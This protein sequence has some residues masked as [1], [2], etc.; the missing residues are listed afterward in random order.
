MAYWWVNQ[1]QTFEEEFLGSYLWAPKQTKNGR[2][3]AHWDAMTDVEVD[4]VIVHY[5]GKPHFQ[6]RSLSVATSGPVNHE[7]PA[8]LRATNMWEDDGW[9][10][11]V[12]H[13]DAV[14]PLHRDRAAALGP[15]EPPFTVTGSVKQGYLWP[16]SPPFARQLLEEMDPTGS[17]EVTETTRSPTA[18][19]E[20][21]EPATVAL[22]EGRSL[23][24]EQ[25]L[26]PARRQAVRAEW[27]LVDAFVRDRDAGALRRRYPLTNGRHLYADA[28][29]PEARVLL[30]A[31]ASADRRAVREAIGQL[32]DYAQK[33][34][35]AVR[36]VVLLPER[37]EEDLLKV[38]DSA[39]ITAIW[40]TGS[41]W[42]A[43]FDDPQL[44][45]PA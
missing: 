23:T 11:H 7:Q 19:P 22:E 12:A 34:S 4:D 36:K 45:S 44:W 20:P 8:S 33:E 31:K 17:L 37:P 35:G 41:G 39:N 25:V 29:F 26:T 9:L 40:R 5:Q 38:L 21:T 28:W 13:V 6:L 32:Y 2:R 16:I 18:A 14:R 30:E 42:S 43:A 15:D 1:G 10:V 24:Y 3:L 27:Q